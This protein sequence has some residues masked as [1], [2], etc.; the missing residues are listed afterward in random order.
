M[1]INKPISAIKPPFDAHQH[2]QQMAA[3]LDLMIDPDWDESVASNLRLLE[4][5]AQ[6]VLSFPLGDDVES[7]LV[8]KP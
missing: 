2:A 5:A 4:A 1:S 3:C 8:F 6:L 7:A